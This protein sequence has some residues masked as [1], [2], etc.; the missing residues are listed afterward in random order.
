MLNSS[1]IVHRG[2]RDVYLTQTTANPPPSSAECRLSQRMLVA[3]QQATTPAQAALPRYGLGRGLRK[4]YEFAPLP[5][6]G[7]VIEFDWVGVYA[8]SVDWR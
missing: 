8:Q 6:S 3:L 2:L 7:G 5:T 1:D 4:A